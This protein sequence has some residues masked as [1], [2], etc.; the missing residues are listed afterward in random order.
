M[1]GLSKPVDE[2]LRAVCAINHPRRDALDRL[3]QLVVVGMVGKRNGVVH[4]KP[5]FRPLIDRPARGRDTD[6]PAD[7]FQVS[8]ARRSD[9]YPAGDRVA[10]ELLE[11][12]EL[13][14][15]RLV[16][17]ADGV[18]VA[19]LQDGN[20]LVGQQPR[21]LLSLAER[22]RLDYRH[23]AGVESLTH[24][25]KELVERLFA[26]RQPVVGMAVG[27]LDHQDVG[28]R[29]FGLGR[30]G[31]LAQ[32]EIARVEQRLSAVLGQQHGR[33]EA[34]SGGK[35]GQSQPAPLD[36]LPVRNLQRPPLAQ[37]VLVQ[38]GRLGSTQSIL[39]AGDMVAMGV[40][41]ERPRL[42]TANV[43]RQIGLGQFQPVF[44][45][46]QGSG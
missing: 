41:D 14:A 45:V 44:P 43:D 7:P 5:L 15:A 10:G 29:Q 2:T 42:T 23:G 26:W 13:H 3:Q 6:L 28:V 17:F 12:A 20:A 32:L 16:H 39:V 37:P 46:E 1:A 35:G 22:V 8:G 33:S 36:R 18:Y 31:R 11:V 19:V 40:R 21:D 34:V 24:Q 27:G 9:D 38:S 4:P 25:R 30:G